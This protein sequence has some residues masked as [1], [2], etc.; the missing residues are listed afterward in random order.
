VEWCAACQQ[1]LEEL[2]RDRFLQDRLHETGL[3]FSAAPPADLRN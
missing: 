3:E 2:T 1:A